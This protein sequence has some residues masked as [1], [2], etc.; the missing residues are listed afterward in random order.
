[1]SERGGERRNLS[2]LPPGDNKKPP[3]LLSAD[4][5]AEAAALNDL[6]RRRRRL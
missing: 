5:F 3:S 2:T 4:V 6:G 1:M